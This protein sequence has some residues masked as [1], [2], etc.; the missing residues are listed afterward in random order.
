MNVYN[1]QGIM[2]PGIVAGAI[3]RD[4]KVM[5]AAYLPPHAHFAPGLE[6]FL[7]ASRG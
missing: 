2:R 6:S 1:W 5:G 3:G 4:A 7:K